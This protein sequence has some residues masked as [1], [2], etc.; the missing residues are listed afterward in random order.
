MAGVI[1]SG[2][3]STPGAPFC[4]GINDGSSPGGSIVV[5]SAPGSSPPP[6]NPAAGNPPAGNPPAGGNG[7]PAGGNAVGIGAVTP[8]PAGSTRCVAVESS[9]SR[10][11]PTLP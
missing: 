4:A 11:G 7:N 1:A 2:A 9:G 8:N 10:S 5:A 6:G 3:L